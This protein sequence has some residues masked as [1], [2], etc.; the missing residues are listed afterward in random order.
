M[1]LG[2]LGCEER[3]V[4]VGVNCSVDVGHRVY[5]DELFNR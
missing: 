1:G 2:L 5:A 3:M 4:V